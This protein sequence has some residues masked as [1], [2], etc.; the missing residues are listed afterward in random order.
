MDS[1]TPNFLAD[2]SAII[3]ILLS[4]LNIYRNGPSVWGT[5]SYRNSIADINARI[6]RIKTHD[7]GVIVSG[8]LS[9]D[10]M[11]MIIESLKANGKDLEKID[12]MMIFRTSD[13]RM[14]SIAETLSKNTTIHT[15]VIADKAV[16]EEGM[17]ALADALMKN[18]TIQKLDI[19]RHNLRLESTKV[20]AKAL[21]KNSIRSLNIDVSRE[22][23]KDGGA[24]LTKA[25]LKN[26]SIQ[27]GKVFFSKYRKFVFGEV[28][29]YD[30]QTDTEDESDDEEEDEEDEDM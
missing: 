1:F 23:G 28:D 30:G 5:E 16:G 10:T 25:L 26:V 4:P 27:S 13:A 7:N 19:G 21:T 24:A 14:K 20:L 18:K 17:I 9:D 22:M 6:K 12:R 3:S 15:V 2:H 11:E 29:K 8:D